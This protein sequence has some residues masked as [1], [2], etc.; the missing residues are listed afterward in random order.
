MS[1]KSSYKSVYADAPYFIEIVD[2]DVAGI[3]SNTPQTFDLPLVPQGKYIL[4]VSP[5]LTTTSTMTGLTVSYDNAGNVG[6]IVLFDGVAFTG[7]R[8]G[9]SQVVFSDGITNISVIVNAITSAGGLWTV[10]EGSIFE[11]VRV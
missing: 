4:L 9:A 2:N 7:F 11:L 3:A 1:F 10:K 6:G 8:T 5:Y